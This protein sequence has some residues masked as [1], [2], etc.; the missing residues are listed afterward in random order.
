[1]HKIKTNPIECVAQRENCKQMI[2]KG[3]VGQERDGIVS[4][5]GSGSA[6]LSSGVSSLLYQHCGCVL[7]EGGPT[8]PGAQPEG[9][10]ILGGYA[11]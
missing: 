7:Q 4:G 2:R 6:C 1:M 8:H 3:R 9:Q 11:C 5:G 10:R